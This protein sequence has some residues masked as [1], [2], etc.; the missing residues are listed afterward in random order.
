MTRETP[1]PE[2]ADL[3]TG[4]RPRAIMFD[5]HGTLVHPDG[6]NLP[7]R[8]RAAHQVLRELPDAPEYAAFEASDTEVREVLRQAGEADLRDYGVTHRFRLVTS[9]LLGRDAP[10]ALVARMV[11]A[12]V[13][14]WVDSLSMPP[15]TIDVLDALR[16]RY[17]LALV[18]DFGDAPGIWRI[19]AR[20][21]LAE[22]FQPVVISADV[23][24][25]KPHPAMFR[26]ALDGLGI[27]PD[28]AVFVGDNL[29]RDVA[30]ARQA[31]IRP[32]LIDVTG[33][34]PEHPG[35]RITDLRELP[36]LLELSVAG[37]QSAVHRQALLG[38]L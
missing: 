17:R 23:G 14:A 29:V 25:I 4:R 36:A 12:Y 16:P 33:Q 28:E 24:H 27:A 5:L 9:A 8:R 37:E 7:E 35:D 38:R 13:D 32:I 20:F 21:S 6:D 11:E 15:E 3:A 18:T 34:Y 10:E 31:G 22:Y 2:P 26:A 19:L 30:G 1:V